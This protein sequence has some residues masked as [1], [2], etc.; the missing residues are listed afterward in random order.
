MERQHWDVG[1][2]LTSCSG[3]YRNHMTRHLSSF[4]INRQLQDS[5]LSKWL[6]TKWLFAGLILQEDDAKFFGIS[7]KVEEGL[8]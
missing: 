3:R 2:F 8:A 7:K 4:R 1:A 5:I 6:E